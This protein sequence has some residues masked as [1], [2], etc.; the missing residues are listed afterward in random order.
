TMQRFISSRIVVVFL[1]LFPI[2]ASAAQDKGFS[3]KWETTYGLMTLEQKDDSAYGQYAMDGARCTIEGKVQG[4]RFQFKY[5]E[6]K[7]SGEGWFELNANGDQFSG[8]WREKSASVWMS[9]VGTRTKDLR[10]TFAGV[11]DTSFGRMRLLENNEGE[12]RGVYA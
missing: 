3:G 2:Q 12:V 9:W 6:P 4:R 7:A 10:K 1:L 8:L 5:R 11:W